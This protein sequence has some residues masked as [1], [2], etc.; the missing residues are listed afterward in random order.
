M[1]Y[2]K[3]VG[4]PIP[5]NTRL[6]I[7]R[8][9][10]SVP[11]IGLEVT[12][13]RMGNP[14]S[15]P[16]YHAVAQDDSNAW[17][18]LGSFCSGFLADDRNITTPLFHRHFDPVSKQNLPG[19]R[20]LFGLSRRLT[21]SFFV[22]QSKKVFTRHDANGAPVPDSRAAWEYLRQVFGR[23][24]DDPVSEPVDAILTPSIFKSRS[25]P[26]LGSVARYAL[27]FYLSSLVRYKPSA[28]DP[29]AQ[30]TVAW[31]FDSFVRESPLPLLASAYSGVIDKPLIFESHGYRV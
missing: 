14:H 7:S 24:V 29:I 10:R 15:E 13:S 25:L 1:L 6:E 5:Y 20:D 21:T 17:V 22:F 8:L 27:M 16:I 18:L 23:Y 4:T 26:M 9:L 12:E 30:A 19:W 11:E 3:R 2:E 31:L 28:L